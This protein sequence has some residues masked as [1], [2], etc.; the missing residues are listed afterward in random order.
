M[1]AATGTLD[2]VADPSCT[3]LKHPVS[4]ESPLVFLHL[5]KVGGTSIRDA[6]WMSAQEKG[7]NM[8]ADLSLP[9]KIMDSKSYQPARTCD[10][11]FGH[12]FYGVFGSYNAEQNPVY[13][14]V[15]RDPIERVLSLYYYVLK[16]EEHYQVGLFFFLQRPF[17]AA[18]AA[19]VEQGQCRE[20]HAIRWGRGGLVFPLCLFLR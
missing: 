9:H 1:P 2:Y 12:L 20:R 8:C 6:L 14:V 19:R 18:R 4:T 15:L 16:Y 10:I 17:C 7:L 3:L 5:P 11:L 13:S